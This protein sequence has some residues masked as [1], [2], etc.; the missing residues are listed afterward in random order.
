MGF[1]SDI[2]NTVFYQP[3]LGALIL[4]YKYLPG[5]DFGFAVII[6]TVLIKFILYP[7]GVKGIKSQ[8]ALQQLKTG[9]LVVRR[10]ADENGHLYAGLKEKEIL[11]TI[12][13]RIGLPLGALKF[14]DY[15]PIKMVGAHELVVTSGGLNEKIKLTVERA[16]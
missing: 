15:R 5:H 12:Q 10:S 7:L 9:G 1:F 3:L 14:V 4:I 11:A 2:F 16:N 8:K 6:L 13:T